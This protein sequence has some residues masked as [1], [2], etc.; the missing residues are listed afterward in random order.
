MTPEQELA[1]PP[2][3]RL[4]QPPE[5]EDVPLQVHLLTLELAEIRTRMTAL[6]EIA[7]ALAELGRQMADLLAMPGL[8]IDE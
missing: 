4:D 6:A 5:W 2:Y 8:L 3:L 7:A 1:L